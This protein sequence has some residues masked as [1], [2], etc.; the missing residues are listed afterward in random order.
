MGDDNFS[1]F[2]Q[3]IIFALKDATRR[4]LKI[5][6]MHGN[7]DFLLG[8]HFFRQTGCVLLPDEQVVDIYGSPTLLLHGDTLCTADKAYLKFRKKSRNWFMQKLFL[9]KSLE[10]RLALAKKYRQASQ[11]HTSTTSDYIM[12][13]TQT[14]VIR[15]M[16]KHH[17]QRLI[18]GHTHREAV[19]EFH[20]NDKPFTR[21]V[22]GAW[23]ESGSALV[24]TSDGKQELVKLF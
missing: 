20:C 11:A 10:A 13:V 24:C 14:E 3:Q 6:I 23:H 18:H 22:L 2:N 17:V 19:H 7:R 21:T 12:D 9:L 8:K 5:H 15:V 4:G 16:Q 1:L